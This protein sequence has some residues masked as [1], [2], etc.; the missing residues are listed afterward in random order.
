M[1]VSEGD[2]AEL[3]AYRTAVAELAGYRFIQA[4][5]AVEG[6]PAEQPVV[7]LI[8]LIRGYIDQLAHAEDMLE[9][10]GALPDW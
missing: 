2:A 1:R 6:T 4:F 8:D 3:A 9:A 7:R 10:N 5:A